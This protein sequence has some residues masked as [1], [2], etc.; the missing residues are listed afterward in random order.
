MEIL[1]LEYYDSFSI[2]V[3]GKVFYFDQEDNKENLVN[4]FKELGLESKYE[5]AY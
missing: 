3:N 2:E 4:V 1:I 5:E